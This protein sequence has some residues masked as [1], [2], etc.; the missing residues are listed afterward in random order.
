MRRTALDNCRTIWNPLNKGGF[1]GIKNYLEANADCRLTVIDVLAK[2]KAGPAKGVDP[3]YDAYE[4]LSPLKALG[5]KHGA[6]ILV[7]H[8]ATKNPPISGDWLDCV[9]GTTG[10]VGVIDTGM[11]I[12]RDRRAG[13]EITLNATGRF[14]KD[15]AELALKFDSGN[16]LV[17]G[18]AEEI[19]IDNDDDMQAILRLLET[20]PLTPADIA[21]AMKENRSTV[22][23][24]IQR[25][26]DASR[27]ERIEGGR[28][29]LPL[30][31]AEQPVLRDD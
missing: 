12:R 6:C 3:Y 11:L 17:I 25:L 5:M 31:D 15:E 21:E 14:M 27:I 30:K 2:V 22:R 20:K 7:L 13:G 4:T 19:R 28:Y 26:F 24:W 16:W 10:I 18:N 1:D 8:H 23:N 9:M 29:A